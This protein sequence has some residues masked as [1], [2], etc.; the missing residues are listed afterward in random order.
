MILITSS[1]D[2]SFAEINYISNGTVERW[3]NEVN[4]TNIV[5]N[6]NLSTNIGFL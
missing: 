1:S 6:V 2:V 3:Q 4:T 5:N